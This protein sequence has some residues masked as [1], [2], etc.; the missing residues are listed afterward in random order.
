MKPIAKTSVVDQVIKQFMSAI[1]SGKWELGEKIPGELE[2]VASLKVSRTSIREALR[3]LSYFGVIISKPGYGTVLAPNAIRLLYNTELALLLS[4]DREV[5]EMFQV[6]IFIEPQIAY[7]AAIKATK[8]DIK[9]IENTLRGSTTKADLEKMTLDKKLEISSNFHR[10]LAETTRN[11][12]IISILDSIQGEIDRLRVEVESEWIPD[13]LDTSLLQHK[14]LLE[15]IKE[16]LP[17]KARDFMFQHLMYGIHLKAGA[18]ND[19]FK[20]QLL[21][22]QFPSV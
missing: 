3:V 21:N 5:E 7:W 11:R 2:L 13:D 19:L 10:A 17:V 6:R 9:R 22:G 14:E 8:V 1:K 15:Y 18:E 12:L 4:Q 16:C 20:K